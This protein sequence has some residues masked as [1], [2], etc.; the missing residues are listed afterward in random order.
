M[1]RWSLTTTARSRDRHSKVAQR[2]DGEAPR[3]LIRSI[4]TYTLGSKWHLVDL[5]RRNAPRKG[6]PRLDTNEVVDGVRPF[7]KMADHHKYWKCLLDGVNARLCPIIFLAFKGGRSRSP[8]SRN[9]RWPSS[10]RCERGHFAPTVA[11]AAV[12]ALTIFPYIPDLATK[13][14]AFSG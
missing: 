5:R 7:A 6:T 14:T 4:S 1:L 12:T 10:R 2:R 11:H 8:Q 13:H 3:L 9:T